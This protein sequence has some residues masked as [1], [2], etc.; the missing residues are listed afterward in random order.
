MNDD[1][2]P[3]SSELGLNGITMG[4]VGVADKGG[5]TTGSGRG[6]NFYALLHAVSTSIP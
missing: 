4:M 5:V 6:Q 2:C 3:T 1:A